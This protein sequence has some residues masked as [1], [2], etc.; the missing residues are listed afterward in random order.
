M[1]EK[2][3]A[4]LFNSHYKPCNNQD[5][6]VSIQKENVVYPICSFCWRKIAKSSLEW[7]SD[8]KF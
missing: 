4:H 6:A 2:C 1:T 5:I 8:E 3:S 7:A